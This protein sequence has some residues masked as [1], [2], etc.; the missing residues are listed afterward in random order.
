MKTC[1]QLSS[2]LV[3]PIYEFF[4]YSVDILDSPKPSGRIGGYFYFTNYCFYIDIY[5]V[6]FCWPLKSFPN[7]LLKF[8]PCRVLALDLEDEP[9]VP[10]V[11]KSHGVI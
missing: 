8:H 10:S 4:V 2:F 6:I 9:R 11:F 3:R 5:N 1:I 7:G